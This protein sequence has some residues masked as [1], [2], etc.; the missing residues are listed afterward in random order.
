MTIS[1]DVPYVVVKAVEWLK[2]EDICE[3]LADIPGVTMPEF[4]PYLLMENYN[5]DWWNWPGAERTYIHT[6]DRQYI[7]ELN[8][9]KAEVCFVFPR[10]HFMILNKEK[11]LH[12]A[13]QD[14]PTVW[15]QQTR[16]ILKSGL[17][18]AAPGVRE[19]TTKLLD[20][21]RSEMENIRFSNHSLEVT[22]AALESIGQRYPR[23]AD[24]A[25]I[26]PI[27]LTVPEIEE[28]LR[29]KREQHSPSPLGFANPDSAS[30]DTD[31]PA[32]G[33]VDEVD[34]GQRTTSTASSQAL[35]EV[36]STGLG[37]IVP[38]DDTIP[39]DLSDGTSIDS[40]GLDVWESGGASQNRTPTGRTPTHRGQ[41]RVIPQYV[42]A[43]SRWPARFP[44]RQN[45]MP[46]VL[47]L[48]NTPSV[49]D[50][51]S[52]QVDQHLPSSSASS[53]SVEATSPVP[54]TTMSTQRYRATPRSGSGSHGHRHVA[55]GDILDL[56]LLEAA[57]PRVPHPSGPRRPPSAAATSST[58]VQPSPK[59]KNK[60]VRGDAAQAA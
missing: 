48:V 33:N 32:A 6:W 20:Y 56:T 1:S 2:V 4:W 36:S 49:G 27:P 9:Y 13:P 47:G 18:P 42:G 50:P 28:F 7:E 57:A 39:D 10:T 5:N 26:L 52:S 60:G 59:N 44:S 30:D 29:M 23:P 43:Q 53:S 15:S 17:Q 34:S 41:V 8:K 11:F 14:T 40:A 51:S 25:R 37:D 12:K 55:A 35:T 31:I 38:S 45:P 46:F 24:A 22:M 21:I 16:P 19:T 54:Q 3:P 58:P